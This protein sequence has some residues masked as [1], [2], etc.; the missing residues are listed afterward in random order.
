[1]R[2]SIKTLAVAS[3]IGASLFLV[4]CNAT[5]TVKK[6]LENAYSVAT[7]GNRVVQ[8]ITTKLSGSALWTDVGGYIGSLD[9]ALA[10]IKTTIEKVAPMVGANLTALESITPVKSTVELDAATAKLLKSIE[11]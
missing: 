3:I 7:E 5:D 2:K 11:Q 9:K 4:G 8:V 1:M 6:V 10:A